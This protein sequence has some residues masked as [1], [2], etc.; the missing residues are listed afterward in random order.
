[1]NK[2]GFNN[3]N[4]KLRMTAYIIN[5]DKN[6]ERWNKVIQNYNNSDMTELKLQRY[7]AIVGKDVY[8][9]NWLSTDAVVELEQ[10]ER[11][12]YRLYH[13]QLTF[14]GIGCFLS[15][16]NV[17][18]KLIDD[19][20]NDYYIIM[21]DDIVFEPNTLNII[22]QSILNAP[23]DWDMLLYGYIRTVENKKYSNAQFMNLNAF[24]GTQGYIVSK[25]GA[26]TFIDD[27]DANKIDGQ[28]DAYLSRMIQ[29]GKINIY[30][31][32][33]KPIRT[34]D[35]ISDIQNQIILQD[36]INPFLFSGYYV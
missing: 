23:S 16:Y 5:M 36:N 27:V 18:K 25:K 4:N 21:E 28:I 7:Q 17:M 15:H 26:K 20:D 9:K 10:V 1:M 6:K 14:G 22:K 19:T 31:Y 29:Q 3:N 8:V 12:K 34:F 32:K 2:D 24:W 11:N 33:N 30:A 13:Y 35:T